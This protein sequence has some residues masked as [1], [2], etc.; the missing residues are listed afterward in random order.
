M[1]LS[2]M[3]GLIAV[4]L[5]GCESPAPLRVKK[6]EFRPMSK[7]TKQSIADQSKDAEAAA[8]ETTFGK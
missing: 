2:V 4:L 8:K 3:L 7:E 1:R 5:S 6:S